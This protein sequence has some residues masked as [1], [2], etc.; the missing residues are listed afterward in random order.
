MVD[1]VIERDRGDS[2]AGWAVAVVV[3]IA[4]IA[5]AGFAWVRYRGAAAPAPASNPVIQVN[6]PAGNPA[7]TPTQ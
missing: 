1:T 5:V 6:V 4:V 2:S 7:P 3:L